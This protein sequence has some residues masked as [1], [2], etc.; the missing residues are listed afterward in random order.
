MDHHRNARSGDPDSSYEGARSIQSKKTRIH[1]AILRVLKRNDKYGA[2]TWEISRVTG[3]LN[4]TVTPRMVEL[5]RAGQ[6]LRTTRR[7][8][9]PSTGRGLIVWVLK[10]HERWV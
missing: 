6:V 10:E 4:W 2:T 8:P 3:I 5:E 9:N 7:R 1:R